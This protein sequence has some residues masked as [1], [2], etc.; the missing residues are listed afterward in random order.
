MSSVIKTGICSYGMSGRV[1]HAPFIEAHPGFELTAIVERHKDESRQLYAGSKLY[2]SIE[3]LC[4]DKTIQ[5]IVVNTPA[6]LH[7]EHATMALNAGENVII[8]KPFTVWLYEAEQLQQLAEEKDLS[9]TIFQ[10]R[11]YDGDFIA[12]KNVVDENLL[13]EIREAEFRYDRYRPNYN[14]SPHKEGDLPG[15]GLLHNL[16]PHLIDQALYLFGWPQA[17]FAD[18]WQMRPDVLSDDYFEILLYYNQLRVRLKGTCIARETVPAYALHGMKGSFLQQRSDL[19]EEKLQQAVKPSLENWC[20]PPAEP[21]GLLHTEINGETV[22]KQTHSDS[23][24]Y[25]R[26]YDDV[27]KALTGKADNPVPATDGVKVMRIM[28]AA[29]ESVKEKRI[30]GL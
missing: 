2:R 3:E 21:D 25:I 29:Q 6:Y 23:G 30:I 13:G 14:G 8:E 16:G 26:F 4:A 11:R 1:F 19:Q 7:L 28:E 17:V 10:N 20:P 9:L 27:Y 12:V 5:L 18:M 15:A 24:N 22:K